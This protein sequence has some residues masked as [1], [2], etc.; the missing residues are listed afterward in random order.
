[1]RTFP[2][3]IEW[4]SL[5]WKVSLIYVVGCHDHKLGVCGGEMSPVYRSFLIDF[6]GILALYRYVMLIIVL[7][8]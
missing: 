7:F 8:S 5:I 4:N 2:V 3:V 6:Q 1:M